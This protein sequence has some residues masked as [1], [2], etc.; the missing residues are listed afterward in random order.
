IDAQKPYL[1][2]AQLEA[3]PAAQEARKLEL[4]LADDKK[5]AEG[6]PAQIA[7]L[8]DDTRERVKLHLT[9]EKLAE[10][11]KVENDQAKTG[12]QLVAMSKDERDAIQ[13]NLTD[14]QK[15]AEQEKI[16]AIRAMSPADLA[17][18]SEATLAIYKRHL[19]QEQTDALPAARQLLADDKKLA[20]GTPAQI[21]E[22]PVETRKR[23]KAELAQDNKDKLAEV[24]KAEEI[25]KLT[26]AELL[27]KTAEALAAVQHYL[28]PK[29][30]E[31]LT[32]AVE[33]AIMAANP[34][35]VA[36]DGENPDAERGVLVPQPTPVIEE[37]VTIDDGMVL[38]DR[39]MGNAVIKD[40]GV[41]SGAGTV[42]S[43]AAQA[44][45]A[46]SPG[47]GIG[48]MHV[49]RDATFDKGS[50]LDIEVGK[51]G[52]DQLAVKGD[53]NLLGGV[54]TLRLED[55][56]QA[57]TPQE[58]VALIGQSHKIVT[59]EG[60]RSGTFDKAEPGYVFIGATLAYNPHDITATLERNGTSFSTHGRTGNQRAMLDGIESLGFGNE[61]HDAIVV[62][63]DSAA[64]SAIAAP[65]VAD[66]QANV[67][68]A[69]I[70][71][72]RFIADA[73]SARVRA[74]FDGV[75]IKPQQSE[76]AGNGAA[77]RLAFGPET[78]KPEGSA[79]FDLMNTGSLPDAT[80]MALWG[81]AY[82]NW[83]HVTGDGNAAGYSGST[84]GFVTGFDGVVADSWRL[85]ILAAHGDTS[86]QSA[87]N[88]ASI[89]SYQVGI[90]GGTQFDALG[91]RFGANIARHEIDSKRN[92]RFGE[93]SN[94]HRAS[95]DA[96]S[97]Q[98]FGEVGYR[99]DRPYATFEPFA[100][101]SYVHLRSSGFTEDGAISNLTGMAGSTDVETTVL[102]LRV[103]HDFAISKSMT[104]TARGMVG[105]SHTFGDTTPEQRLS[106]RGGR[107]FTAQGVATARNIAL[108]EAG[109]DVNIGRN[110]SVGISYTGQFSPDAKDN[111]IKA[112][113][114]VQF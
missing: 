74:A 43:L 50:L 35:D 80:T 24:E 83:S 77:Q 109:I 62:S 76:A 64:P 51:A 8:S 111:S 16:D 75:V 100:A 21:A 14:A 31:D 78:G 63:K 34:T 86:L 105:W 113:L 97:V 107:E 90:Y 104:L 9:P 32:V 2:T 56:S 70:S 26:T 48:T 114:S 46:V 36:T 85:G 72:S 73:A 23:V 55:A 93:A 20:K 53:L 3:L 61:L 112:D 33:A 13:V 38:L 25:Q 89:D 4:Q 59:F 81:Q 101:A 47:H 1:S 5:L 12:E 19:T 15:T 67:K 60:K 10:V 57:L 99:I 11:E 95:Y 87:G 27:A 29:Q 28:T 110:T 84:G 94:T 91:L 44:G 18:Q 106:F 7:E 82:G 17:R 45:G 65:L 102:G 54:V 40:G 79:A 6:E 39:R 22:L 96:Q 68:S 52:A 37:E 103:S 66:I 58:T 98:L 49:E 30:I 88:K 92:A 42:A 108:V 41:L 71:G 69:L